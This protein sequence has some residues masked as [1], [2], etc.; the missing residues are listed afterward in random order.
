MLTSKL[1]IV[2]ITNEGKHGQNVT[3]ALSILDHVQ[4]IEYFVVDYTIIARPVLF[5]LMIEML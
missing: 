1:H 2:C 3:K 4:Q 5:S